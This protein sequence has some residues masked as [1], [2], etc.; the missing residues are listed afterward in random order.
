MGPHVGYRLRE[1]LRNVE[2]DEEHEREY[3]NI[4][5]AYLDRSRM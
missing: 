4:N 2:T 3:N 5:L 1:I